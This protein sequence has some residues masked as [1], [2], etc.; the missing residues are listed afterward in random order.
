MEVKDMI[1]ITLRRSC[2]LGLAGTLETL[3]EHPMDRHKMTLIAPTARRPRLAVWLLA[4][5]LLGLAVASASA[6]TVVGTFRY[7]DSGE[8]LLPIAHVKVESWG[9]A[10]RAL[11]V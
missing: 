9:C 5:G 7:R 6:E 2:F 8:G 4:I 11:D 1:A 10:P 3:E